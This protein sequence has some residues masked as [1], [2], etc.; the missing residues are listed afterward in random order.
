MKNE[1]KLNSK[2][3]LITFLIAYII[4]TILATASSIG[5]SIFL[6]VPAVPKSGESVLQAPNFVATVPFHVLIMFIIWP[7]FTRYYFKK[8]VPEFKETLNLALFWL[9][10]AIVLDY[11]AYVMPTH[12]Y[13]LTHY[14]FYVIYQPWIS[15]IYL[16]IFSSPFIY[17]WFFLRNGNRENSPN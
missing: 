5:Y 9:I 11:L 17:R 12:A 10:A 8:R 6:N 4:V 16:A 2:R 7:L 3:A 14:E 1:S 15:L 13:A